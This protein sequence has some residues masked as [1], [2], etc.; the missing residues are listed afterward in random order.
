MS[1]DFEFI[2]ADQLSA[3]LHTP[4]KSLAAPN[5][6]GKPENGSP[7]TWSTIPNAQVDSFASSRSG[8]ESP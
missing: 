7:P 4:V 3:M 1:A 8:F 6:I 5:K 2:T